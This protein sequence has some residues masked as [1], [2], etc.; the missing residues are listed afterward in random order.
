MVVNDLS[1]HKNLYCIDTSCSLL[2]VSDPPRGF[3][4]SQNGHHLDNKDQNTLF[5]IF[6]V[7][8]NSGIN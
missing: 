5:Q 8:S 1:D 2:R 7:Y 4:F 3:C 6:W